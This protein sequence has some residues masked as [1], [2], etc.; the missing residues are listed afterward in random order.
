MGEGVKDVQF[1]KNFY[2]GVNEILRILFT[3]KGF[4]MDR[5]E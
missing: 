2:L 5:V 4:K 3:K 1:G